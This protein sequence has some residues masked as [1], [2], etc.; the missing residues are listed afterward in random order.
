MY[1]VILQNKPRLTARGNSWTIEVVGESP[2]K[3]ALRQS[4]SELEHHPARAARRSLIDML[5]LIEQHRLKIRHT[6]HFYTDDDLEGWTFILQ[7]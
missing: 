5:G 6:E 2:I 4:I 3:K 7:G 1:T